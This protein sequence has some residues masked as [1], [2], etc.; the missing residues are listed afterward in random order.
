[1]VHDGNSGG[2]LT[3]EHVVSIRGYVIVNPRDALASM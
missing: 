2:G 1:M 3:R